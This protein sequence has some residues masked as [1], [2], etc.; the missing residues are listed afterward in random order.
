MKIIQ[1]SQFNSTRTSSIRLHTY[2]VKALSPIGY[3]PFFCLVNSGSSV[4]RRG[5]LT[6]FVH[7]P[8]CTGFHRMY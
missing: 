5:Q 4:S 1:I 3:R 6:D 8:T 7:H 2:R